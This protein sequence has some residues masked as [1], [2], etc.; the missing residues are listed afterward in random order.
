MPTIAL[1]DL[2]HTH[3]A[4]AKGCTY[5][6]LNLRSQLCRDSPTKHGLVSVPPRIWLRLNECEMHGPVV[7]ITS[8]QLT[9]ALDSLP[10][11]HTGYKQRQP[12]QL[13]LVTAQKSVSRP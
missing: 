10:L 5:L 6:V 8:A 12:R 9:L 11:V 3:L 1:I 2:F 7:L 13:S 4:E